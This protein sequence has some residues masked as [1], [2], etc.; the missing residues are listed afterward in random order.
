MMCFKSTLMST[1]DCALLVSLNRVKQGR[2]LWP[3]LFRLDIVVVLRI[4]HIIGKETTLVVCASICI[5]T[6]SCIY[7]VLDILVQ[8][9]Y[10]VISFKR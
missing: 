1:E 6:T 3:I 2:V 9:I 4:L 8:A 7:V 5:Y 10:S